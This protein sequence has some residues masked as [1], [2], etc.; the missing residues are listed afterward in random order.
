M[1]NTELEE[2]LFNDHRIRDI[3]GGVYASDAIPIHVK[4]SLYYT[5][6]TLTLVTCQENIGW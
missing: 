2:K 5:L 3:V 1:N 6:L 4:K